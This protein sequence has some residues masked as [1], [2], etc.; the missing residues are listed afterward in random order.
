MKL[1]TFCNKVHWKECRY[2]S[3][4]L[5]KVVPTLAT[6]HV[7]ILFIYVVNEKLENKANL[8]KEHPFLMHSIRFM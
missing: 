6:C 4:L 2:L 1:Y 8:M 7:Q 3:Q 5:I